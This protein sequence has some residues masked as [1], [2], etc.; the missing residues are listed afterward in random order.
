MQ[1]YIYIYG[2]NSGCAV[3]YAYFQQHLMST[4]TTLIVIFARPSARCKVLAS[5]N[6]YAPFIDSYQADYNK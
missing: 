2:Y 6:K 5:V 1:G 4:M 3:Y